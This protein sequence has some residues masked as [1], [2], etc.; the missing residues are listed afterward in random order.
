M[1][2]FHRRPA[3]IKHSAERLLLTADSVEVQLEVV[4]RVERLRFSAAQEIFQG[5]QCIADKRP[6]ANPT[7]LARLS[8]SG[9][10][11]HHGLPS[12]SFASNFADRR[13]GKHVCCK[14]KDVMEAAT[15]KNKTKKSRRPYHLL[16]LYRLIL[17]QGHL[18]GST[19]TS[20]LCL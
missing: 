9:P 12:A 7:F 15:Q 16:K 8:R 5:K 18:R 4:L 6:T 17:S 10:H 2:W 14:P 13:V 3:R 19:Q 1:S 20:E 11:L